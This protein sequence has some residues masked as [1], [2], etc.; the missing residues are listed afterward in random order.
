MVVISSLKLHSVGIRTVGASIVSALLLLGFAATTSKA[1]VTQIP[2][3]KLRITA[4]DEGQLNVRIA[5]DSRKYFATG[6]GTGLAGLVLFVTSPD[7]YQGWGPGQDYAFTKTANASLTGTGSTS[8]PYRLVNRYAVVQNAEVEPERY[9]DITQTITH[10]A[11]SMAFKVAYTITNGIAYTAGF[12]AYQ[13][14]VFSFPQATASATAGPP[15]RITVT[16]TDGRFATLEEVVSDPFARYAVGGES[17]EY[18]GKNQIAQVYPA[19][20]D[21]YDSLDPIPAGLV[22]DPGLGAYWP[23]W[24]YVG[25][26]DPGLPPG[27]TA[28]LSVV[29]RFGP[30]QGKTAVTEPVSGTVKVKVPGS[31]QFQEIS[32]EIPVGSVIDTR[33]GRVR[34][35]TAKDSKGNTQTAEFKEGLF[36]LLQGERSAQTILKLTGPKD[37]KSA[38]SARSASSTSIAPRA[39]KGRGRT[40]WGSGRGKFSSRGSRGS[41]SVRGTTWRVTDRC[42]GSTLIQSISGKVLAKDTFGKKKGKKLLS[43]GMKFVAK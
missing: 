23:N 40:L 12:S 36:K 6:D 16:G 13:V 20:G 25:D 8:N 5:G 22:S 3:S 7:V 15:R 19:N 21:S 4:S 42:D 31:N 34:L 10:R 28:R 33:K 11:D 27:D 32:G 1:A 26:S 37:C 9:F 14:G 18:P 38:A 24:Q 17:P 41:G 39:K 29:W 43:S 2:G 30:E 35:T